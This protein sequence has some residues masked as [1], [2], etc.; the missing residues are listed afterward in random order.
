MTDH[1]LNERSERPIRVLGNPNGVAA[2]YTPAEREVEARSGFGATVR[3]EHRRASGGADEQLK[4]REPGASG[5]VGWRWSTAR[6]TENGHRQ[7]TRMV[8]E[9][10]QTPLPV[11]T[12][13]KRSH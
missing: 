5:D 2:L 13:L 4:R 11:A 10:L 1:D 7:V 3:R 8:K 6:M 12:P 9:L